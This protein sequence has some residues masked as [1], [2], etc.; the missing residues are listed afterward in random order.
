MFFAS[1]LELS[2]ELRYYCYGETLCAPPYEIIHNAD[3][4]PCYSTVLFCTLYHCIYTLSF[5]YCSALF[6]TLVAVSVS[7][8]ILC[9]CCTS[10]TVSSVQSLYCQQAQGLFNII[11]HDIL[12]IQYS[13]LTILN[14]R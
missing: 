2:F 10:V 14:L 7:S 4:I 6:C 3:K 11:L 9:S 8:I 12:N 1:N 13:V 5:V